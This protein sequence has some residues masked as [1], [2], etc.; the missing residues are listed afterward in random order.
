MRHLRINLSFRDQAKKHLALFGTGFAGLPGGLL[1][2]W[3]VGEFAGARL[4]AELGRAGVAQAQKP[5]DL[6]EDLRRR[7]EGLWQ[8]NSAVAV[9]RLLCK[10]DREYALQW[11]ALVHL[12]GCSRS[13]FRLLAAVDDNLWHTTS[14]EAF[15]QTKTAEA[16]ASALASPF[17]SVWVVDNYNR[18]YFLRGLHGGGK[19][20]FDGQWF[21]CGRKLVAVRTGSLR[22]D[23]DASA[24]GWMPGDLLHR[25]EFLRQ[26]GW[27]CC[28]SHQNFGLSLQP[29][30]VV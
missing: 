10:A 20:R 9:H 17:V 14:V 26:V 16:Q 22:V 28:G 11:A 2:E 1:L 8:E 3:V 25:G 18:V 21:A 30:F 29:K 15:L 19:D 27:S 13:T 24:V 5:D 4:L 7:L 12:T 23:P 6:S